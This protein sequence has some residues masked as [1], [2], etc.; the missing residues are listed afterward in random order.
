MVASKIRHYS[1]KSQKIYACLFLGL[2][3]LNIEVYGGE[4][5]IDEMLELQDED[6]LEVLDVD[7]VN[8][9]NREGEERPVM[10]HEL[11]YTKKPLMS[12]EGMEN[13]QKMGLEGHFL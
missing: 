13:M 9:D 3:A 8:D 12:L 10:N 7:G 11:P 1:S 6:V 5:H 4:A 2:K